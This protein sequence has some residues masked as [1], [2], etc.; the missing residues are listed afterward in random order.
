[1][2]RIMIIIAVLGLLGPAQTDENVGPLSPTSGKM[3]SCNT[4]VTVEKC[5]ERAYDGNNQTYAHSTDTASEDNEL[6][7][8]LQYQKRH[9]FHFVKLTFYRWGDGW[10]NDNKAA[11]LRTWR[12][13]EGVQVS[14]KY[15]NEAPEK[16]V[17]CGK[18]PENSFVDTNGSRKWS[19][20]S[21]NR[22]AGRL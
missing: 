15:G 20:S 19:Y 6:T 8:E 17:I 16:E 18:V 9:V 14:V 3:S 21:T 11:C 1:M 5:A 7:L 4:D 12:R 2:K 22:G 10:C 13:L